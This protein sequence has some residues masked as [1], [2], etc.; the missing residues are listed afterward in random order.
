[1]HPRQVVGCS[2]P[3]DRVAWFSPFDE[4]ADDGP[5]PRYGAGRQLDHRPALPHHWSN[6]PGVQADDPQDAVVTVQ[7][8]DIK[9][10]GE[11]ERVNTVTRME[12]ES[13]VCGQARAA[14]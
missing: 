3:R 7:I 2:I 11:E 8:Y 14:N 1:M 10:K 5:S 6:V 9:R 4:V 12:H 13:V